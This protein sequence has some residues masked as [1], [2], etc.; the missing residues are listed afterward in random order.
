MDPDDLQLL[1]TYLQRGLALRNQ[2]PPP[3]SY[4]EQLA[5][6]LDDYGARQNGGPLTGWGG[7]WTQG[8]PPPSPVGPQ[9][10]TGL[11]AL[12]AAAVSGDVPTGGGDF[13]G[14]PADGQLESE[15]LLLSAL[16]QSN[17]GHH[18]IELS[19]T[20]SN[21]S[22]QTFPRPLAR[23]IVTTGGRD[24]HPQAVCPPIPPAPPGVSVDQNMK[25]AQLHGATWYYNQV[26]NKGPWDYKQQ[27]RQYQDF[28][29]FNYGATAAAWGYPYE[30]IRRM[31]G[32]AQQ[33]AGTS[34]PAWGSP[35]GPFPYGDDPA[36]QEM[37]DAGIRYHENGCR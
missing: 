28:G 32:W 13:G 7:P 12:G 35:L 6:A 36:D 25:E 5:Q 8:A 3:P 16:N 24:R 18:Q 22:G 15:P 2:P 31:A 37:I 27:G 33:R 17:F 29:N 9:G 1:D 34:R 26:R 21:Q 23:S 20:A 14:A 19:S 10:L 4:P 11:Y 30:V